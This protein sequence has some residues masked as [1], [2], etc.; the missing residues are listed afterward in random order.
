MLFRTF[1]LPF[2]QV[3]HTNQLLLPFMR[4]L[5]AIYT[6][7]FGLLLVLA[8]A[9]WL[10]L[11][12]RRSVGEI[13]HFFV[14]FYFI[15]KA[16]R[17]LLEGLVVTP[18][19]S[20]HSTI[21]NL[22]GRTENMT[23]VT[24]DDE[25]RNSTNSRSFI[26]VVDFGLHHARMTATV[27]LAILTFTMCLWLQTI[28]QG[29]YLRRS[30][31]ILLSYFN[32]PIGLA[33]AVLINRVLFPDIRVPAIK[34]PTRGNGSF[35]SLIIS[36]PT[37]L[38]S[39][40]S[41]GT[42]NK[43]TSFLFHPHS[44]GLAVLMALCLVPAIATETILS[45]IVVAKPERC[46]RKPCLFSLDLAVC[47]CI[48]PVICALLG[49]PFLSPAPVRSNAHTV[50]L[51]KWNM[52]TPPGVPH[53]IVGCVEQRLTGLGIGVLVTSSLLIK[54]ELFAGIPV[55]ALHG[56]FLYMG[57]MGLRDLVLVRR[58][59][60]L[61]KYRKHW[62]DREY[63]CHVPSFTIAAFVIIQLGFIMLLLALNWLTEFAEIGA[64]SLVFPYILL[65]FAV[66]REQALPRC[67]LFGPFLE[68]MDKL[69]PLQL[70]RLKCLRACQHSRILMYRSD[71]HSDVPSSHGG[72]RY[73]SDCKGE[74][75]DLANIAPRLFV[76]SHDGGSNLYHEPTDEDGM[77]PVKHDSNKVI[78]SSSSWM[79]PERKF[80]EL[81]R[82]HSDPIG[83]DV[84]TPESARP[85]SLTCLNDNDC[86]LERTHSSSSAT[87]SSVD[88]YSDRELQTLLDNPY[89]L[90]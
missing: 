20:S 73:P 41:A 68:Q 4:L 35:L 63:L 17:S 87:L 83:L 75:T 9:G 24:T 54:A 15:Y 56:M 74:P 90:D 3:C 2:L 69:H 37:R 67:T 85:Q 89:R 13:F 70:P 19:K 18:V 42:A 60:A 45:G 53:R 44:H 80:S 16:L 59:C 64:A 84:L 6:S 65:T 43:L 76:T 29:R 38:S 8:N 58:V 30:V 55:G 78:N 25:T 49:W 71:Y 5:I 36:S 7:M 21:N 79:K 62:K 46:L 1:F 72:A 61:L 12:V 27:L 32:V 50:A 57:T 40:S 11:R 52:R 31:R 51:T 26:S 47:L 34:M 14:S 88:E 77:Q 86:L 10:V 22:T 23:N 28:K 48:L 33:C 66:L 82:C 81:C 39:S